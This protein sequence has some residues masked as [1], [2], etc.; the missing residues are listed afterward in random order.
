MSK[1]TKALLIAAIAVMLVGATSAY[2]YYE[3]WDGWFNSGYL[4]YGDTYD[5][6]SGEGVLQDR[7]YGSVDSFFVNFV[8]PSTF[9]CE[10]GEYEGYY[11]ML[12][13]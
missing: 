2:G 10:S 4:T 7:T 3:H 1:T 11:I 12:W 8:T 6:V 5:Y 13:P 9:T